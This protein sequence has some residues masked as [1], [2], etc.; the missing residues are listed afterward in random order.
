MIFFSKQHRINPKKLEINYLHLKN[1]KKPNFKFINNLLK[2]K[3][4]MQ[5][6]EN[7]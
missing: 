2:P 3:L 6:E 1:Q 5:P 7:F 4:W